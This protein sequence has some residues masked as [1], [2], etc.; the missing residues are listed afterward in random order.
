MKH[1]TKVDQWWKNKEST[2]TH[3]YLSYTPTPTNIQ[4]KRLCIYSHSQKSK[5][6]R[7]SSNKPNQGGEGDLKSLKKEIKTFRNG[8]TFHT[9]EL[10]ELMVWKL[11]LHQKVLRDLFQFQPNYHSTKRYLKIYFNSNQNLH[12]LFREIEK[13]TNKKSY[14]TTQKNSDTQNNSEQKEQYWIIILDFSSYN[15]E[16]Q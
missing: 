15:R 10:L 2:W 8:N 12:L 7:I 4:E 13:K 3:Q 16:P 1:T 6:N 5:E 14:E 9:Y 11:P